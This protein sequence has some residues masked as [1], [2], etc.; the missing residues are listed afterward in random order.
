M[1]ASKPILLNILLCDTIFRDE[2]TKKLSLI[3]L[4]DNINAPDFPCR[5]FRLHIYIAVTEGIG[6]QKGEVRFI[7]TKNN[8]TIAKLEGPVSF[9]NKLAVVELNFCINNLTF[10]EPGLYCVE[11]LSDGYP[12]GSRKFRVNKTGE[13]K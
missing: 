8:E 11:F 12:V 2:K 7:N 13:Q 10:K 1:T 4:F 6:Q 3:G 5:H 9:P